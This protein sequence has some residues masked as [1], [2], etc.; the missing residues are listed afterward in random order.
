MS[1]SRIEIT[2]SRAATAAAAPTGDTHRRWWKRVL[3]RSLYGRSLIIIILPLV[4]AELIGTGVF[5]D[6][7]WDTV[8]RR[9][10][11]SVASDVGF[12]IDAMRYA[13][14]DAERAALLGNAKR[15]TD[16]A[17]GYLPGEKLPPGMRQLGHSQVEDALAVAID[18]NVRRPFQLDGEFDPRDILIS[19]QLDD[20]VLQVAAPRKRLYTPTGYIFVLWMVGSGV[21]LVAIASLFMRNQVRA[22][23]RL[24]DAAD[25]FGKGRDVPNFRPEGATEVRR[26]AAAFLKMRERLQRQLTQ[27]TEMLAGVS[28][29]LRTPLTRMRLALEFLTDNPAVGEL[30]HDVAV[31]QRMVEGYLDFAKGEGQGEPEPTDLSALVEDAAAVARRA[32]AAISVVAPEQCVV[33]LRPDAIHRC[34]ANLIGNAQRYGGRIWLTVTPLT[35]SV[36]VLVDDDG[37]GVPA[38]ERENVFRP[39]FRLDSARSPATE[40]VGLGLTIARDVARGHGGDLRLEDSPRGGL[41]VR[42]ILPK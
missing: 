29:D 10:A 11:D 37:P 1:S 9:L 8:I 20:G 32:G 19:V 3:P 21:V 36:T 23:R 27:R 33:P 7:V 25:S 22:L 35:D 41:R 2:P 42:L 30:Q 13:D 14:N 34:L 31:M 6:R 40:G 12:T 4:L 17:F 26:A 16:L 24:A 39:F 5:Y 38:A 15:L 28:H 18:N